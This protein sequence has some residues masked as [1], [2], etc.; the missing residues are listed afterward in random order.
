METRLLEAF[1]VLPQAVQQRELKLLELV[2]TAH[3]KRRKKIKAVAN[4]Q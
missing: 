3:S 4:N 2:A 1:R